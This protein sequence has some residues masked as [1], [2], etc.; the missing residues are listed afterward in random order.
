MGSTKSLSQNS[1]KALDSPAVTTQDQD[2]VF[3]KDPTTANHIFGCRGLVGRNI[4]K[5][6]FQYLRNT[7]YGYSRA[8]S[9]EKGFLHKQIQIDLTRELDD[10]SIDG[11]VS[12]EAQTQNLIFSAWSGH[13]RSDHSELVS[14]KEANKRL[15]LN[16]KKLI[17]R[18]MP[19][20]VVFIS[21]SGALCKS[22]ESFS[23]ETEPNPT[24]QYGIQKLVAEQELS[25]C[26]Q[27][28]G[29]PIGILRISSA[30]GFTDRAKGLGV[31]NE[32]SHK[33]ARGIP[34]SLLRPLSSTVNLISEDILRDATAFCIKNHLDGIFNISSSNSVSLGEIVNCF[35]ALGFEPNLIK[36]DLSNS[37]SFETLIDNAK[38][39]QAS[40]LRLDFDLKQETKAILSKVL[41]TMRP[42]S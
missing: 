35:A 16:Y 2:S 39:K 6:S 11:I 26:C 22:G 3:E 36:E 5:A 1:T 33:V 28:L 19:D 29:I 31:V 14:N 38:F 25:A 27:D 12:R 10:L 24:T 30:S 7:T 15:V 41:F 17:T 13:P 9:L 21:S 32:W 18:T 37:M 23:E 42:R 4:S 34:I 20:Y 8:R 40:G